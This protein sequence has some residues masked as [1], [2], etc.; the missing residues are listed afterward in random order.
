MLLSGWI[1]SC[2]RVP[3]ALG[4]P[5]KVTIVFV[6]SVYL[7]VRPS[8]WN[9]SAPTGRI[10]ITFDIRA[11]FFRKFVEKIRRKIRQE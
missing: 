4:K 3:V 6:M 5:R 11:F 7:S 10:L 1:V 8:A 2:G 9:N